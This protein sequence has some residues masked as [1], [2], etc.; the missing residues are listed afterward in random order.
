MSVR[1]VLLYSSE[2]WALKADIRRLPVL[3]HRCLWSTG[4]IWWEHRISNIEVRR[5]VLGP[6][7][8]SITEQLHDHRL[9]WPRHVLLTPNDRLPGRALFA[10]P[11]SS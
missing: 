8:M 6:K 4:K 10:E 7:N 11:K 3:D 1:S 5:R 9:R 2:T